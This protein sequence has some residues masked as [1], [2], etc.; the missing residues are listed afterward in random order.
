MN[1]LWM[2]PHAEEVLSVAFRHDT[3]SLLVRAWE[4]ACG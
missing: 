2:W 4:E 1:R 3:G